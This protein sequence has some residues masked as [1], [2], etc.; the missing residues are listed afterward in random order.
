MVGAVPVA[1]FTCDGL[2][3]VDFAGEPSVCRCW[4]DFRGSVVVG[5]D[6]KLYPSQPMSAAEFEEIVLGQVAVTMRIENGTLLG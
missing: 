5:F 1:G 6:N 4:S 3:V 2:Y